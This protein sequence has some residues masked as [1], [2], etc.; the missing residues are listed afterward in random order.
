MFGRKKKLIKKMSGAIDLVKMGIYMRLE[1]NFLRKY[2]ED[3]SGLLSAAIVNVLFDQSPS[4]LKASEFSASNKDLIN[5]ELRNLKDDE[6]IRK[7]VT[8]AVR[9][10]SVLLIAQDQNAAVSCAEHLEK[11]R[12]LGILIPGGEAPS[13]DFL[14]I[15]EEFYQ[16]SV[17]DSKT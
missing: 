6:D 7:V 9:A 15:A 14:S 4:N 2:A 16:L 13:L 5:Q 3:F 8:E 1:S 11:L 10:K 12:D 17:S